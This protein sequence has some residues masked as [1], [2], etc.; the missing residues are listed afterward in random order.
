[1]RRTRPPERK[2]A[3]AELVRP[4][5]WIE[6]A[7]KPVLP[8]SHYFTLAP[9]V[10]APVASVAGQHAPQHGSQFVGQPGQGASQHDAFAVLL[11]AVVLTETVAPA[12]QHSSQSSQHSRQSVSQPGQ[13]TSQHDGVAAVR[14]QLLQPE[15][16]GFSQAPWNG[17]PW[18]V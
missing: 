16:C 13:G 2:N 7:G 15:A 14:L 12:E 6:R 17:Q 18:L 3:R 4:C 8:K 5:L 9:A 10:A 11:V 1:M